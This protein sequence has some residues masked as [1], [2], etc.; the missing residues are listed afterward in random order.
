MA[1]FLPKNNAMRTKWRHTKRL[2][3]HLDL[4]AVPCLIDSYNLWRVFAQKGA[5]RRV[6]KGCQRR[7]Q[8]G[9]ACAALTY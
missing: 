7:R 3:G 1:L 9:V 2:Y 8:K 6:R 4:L 5:A